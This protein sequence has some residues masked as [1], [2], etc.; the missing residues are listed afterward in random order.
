MRARLPKYW[1][2]HFLPSV[3]NAVKNYSVSRYYL[4][5]FFLMVRYLISDLSALFW[6]IIE[7]GVEV[8]S[9]V[10]LVVKI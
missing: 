4:M 7:Q 8:D 10:F 2:L 1:Y 6:K 3:P 9:W 5:R